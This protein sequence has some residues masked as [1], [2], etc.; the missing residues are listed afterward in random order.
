MDIKSIFLIER[1]LGLGEVAEM[2]NLPI[3]PIGILLGCLRGIN[4]LWVD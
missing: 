3:I 4:E 1:V 2:L